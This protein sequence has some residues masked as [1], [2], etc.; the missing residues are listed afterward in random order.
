M[1][2]NI[3]YRYSCNNVIV[4]L[5]DFKKINVKNAGKDKTKCEIGKK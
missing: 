3:G 4:F 5:L 2:Y 1:Q